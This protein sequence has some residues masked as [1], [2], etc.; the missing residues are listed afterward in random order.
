ML[1]SPHFPRLLAHA[2]ETTCLTNGALWSKTTN[3]RP[4]GI[5]SATARKKSVHD[6]EPRANVVGADKRPLEGVGDSWHLARRCTRG[7]FD[8]DQRDRIASRLPTG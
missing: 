5:Q 7:A 1:P 6:D 3:G 8:G 4:P 2:A